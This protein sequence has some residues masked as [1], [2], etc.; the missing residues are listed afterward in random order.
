M[1]RSYL[2]VRL[3]LQG[4]PVRVRDVAPGEQSVEAWVLQAGCMVL[5]R[6][7]GERQ[8]LDIVQGGEKGRDYISMSWGYERG[9]R[10]SKEI[11]N[12]ECGG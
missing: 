11:G 2:Q 1:K 4:L 7:G 5:G 6:S 10:G 3:V 9:I 12:G 8:R